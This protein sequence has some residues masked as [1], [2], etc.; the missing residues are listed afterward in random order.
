LVK[1]D[2]TTEKKL[3]ANAFKEAFE[4]SVNQRSQQS[5]NLIKHDP[6]TEKNLT[7]KMIK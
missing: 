5:K 1:H 4:I 2:P 3:I 6:T 7:V